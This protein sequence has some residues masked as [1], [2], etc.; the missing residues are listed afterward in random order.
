MNYLQLSQRVTSELGLA[1]SGP[2]AVT[3]QVGMDKKIV[4]WVASAWEEI[5]LMRNDWRFNWAT[6]SINIT[7]GQQAHYPASLGLADVTQWIPDTLKIGVN[8][9]T[10]KAWSDFTKYHQTVERG[11]PN[12]YSLAPDHAIHLSKVPDIDY[13]LT[14][15]YYR[16]PQV[17]ASNG[18]TP[19]LP[20]R[21]HMAIV[22]KAMMMYAPHD[23]AAHI[24]ADAKERYLALVNKIESTELSSTI[25]LA[26]GLDGYT[27]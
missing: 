12:L 27:G 22:Y 14:G 10:P 3:N 23:E 7:A 15:E 13:V 2:A 17:L 8:R 9:L 20:E 11:L 6:G 25:V 4:N 5:Q 26:G 16:T 1:G 21:Y 18:D 24:Y 19:R